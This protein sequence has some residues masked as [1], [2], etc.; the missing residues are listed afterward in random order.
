MFGLNYRG[1]IT[2]CEY[3][4]RNMYMVEY[5]DDVGKIERKT[6]FEDEIEMKDK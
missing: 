4:G 2:W 6:F 5:A 1:R 3:D